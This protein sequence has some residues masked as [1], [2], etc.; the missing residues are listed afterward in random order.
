MLVTHCFLRMLRPSISSPCDDLPPPPFPTIR[1]CPSL[2]QVTSILRGRPNRSRK[3]KIVSPGCNCAHLNG[4]VGIS[5]SISTVASVVSNTSVAISRNDLPSKHE[6]LCTHDEVA[7]SQLSFT[8]DR[9][10]PWS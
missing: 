9:T 8:P 5:P 7:G 1:T 4:V 10:T 2:L 3:L 6:S